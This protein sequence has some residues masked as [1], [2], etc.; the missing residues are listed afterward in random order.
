MRIPAA[1][2]FVLLALAAWRLYRL[3][4]YDDIT[5]P[6]RE[7]LVRRAEEP[8]FVYVGDG[9]YRPRLDTFVHCPYCL[10]FWICVAGWVA[11]QVW[12]HGMVWLAV[13][14][15]ASAVLVLIE[16][17]HDAGDPEAEAEAQRD[18]R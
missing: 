10:G 9:N 6:M 16:V 8:G 11:Y 1:F 17:N 5:R 15:A 2:E 14:W 7:R 18:A 12:P 13:P 3:A 4:A